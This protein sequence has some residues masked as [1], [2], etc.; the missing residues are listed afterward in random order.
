MARRAKEAKQPFGGYLKPKDMS[1][2][3]YDDGITLHE[4]ENIHSSLVGLSVDYLTRFLIN[5]DIYKSFEISIKGARNLRKLD[6]IEKILNNI[7]GLDDNSII[8]TIY[9]TSFDVAYRVSPFQ[10]VPYQTLTITKDTIENIRT[11][12]TRATTFFKNQGGITKDGFDFKGSYTY[13]IQV[14]DG[15]F[16]TKDTLWDMKTI[17]GPVTKAHTLQLLIYFLMGKHTGQ[18]IFKDIHKVG[19][20][21]PRLNAS[22]TYDINNLL[23]DIIYEVETEVIGYDNDDKKRYYFNRK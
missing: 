23:D 13:I 16:L 22:F 8:N 2:V 3:Q 17:K 5:Q 4:V 6:E 18:E 15:D 7:K 12:V 1:K 10:Y 14:G 19:I 9:A 20:F 11:M 21:N